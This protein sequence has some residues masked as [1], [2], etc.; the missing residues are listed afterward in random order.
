MLSL[1]F[2]LTSC[3]LYAA[4]RK[5][6][7]F[8]N[9]LAPTVLGGGAIIGG[10]EMPIENLKDFLSSLELW[11]QVVAGIIVLVIGAIGTLVIRKIF[12]KP[13]PP[14]LLSPPPP[15]V[16]PSQVITRPEAKEQYFFGPGS[17]VTIYNYQDGV[18]ESP[19]ENVRKLFEEGRQSAQGGDYK[20]AIEHFSKILDMEDDPEKRGALYIQIGN[21]FYS[22]RQYVKAHEFYA[23]ALNE[24]EKAGDTEGKGAALGAIA[25]TYMMRPASDASRRGENVRTAVEFYSQ[26]LS[27]FPKDAFPIQFAMTQ[28]NLG[29]AY[30]DLPSATTEERAANVRKAIACYQA[31]LD[32]YRKDEYPVDFAMTQNN[33]GN[34]LK[35]LPSSSGRRAGHKCSQGD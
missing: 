19:K 2:L 32:I 11:Q 29:N 4:P 35:A 3:Y 23:K 24:A 28:N 20:G 9:P 12:R 17:N 1:A 33:L 7:S 14:E 5:A 25:N 30:T 6:V 26:A 16:P 13:R 34:A 15:T 27:I 18:A 31:A 10:Y 22:L 21:S 8:I